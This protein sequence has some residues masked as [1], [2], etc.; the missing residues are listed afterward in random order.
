[1]SVETEVLGQLGLTEAEA[2][3]YLV[4]IELGSSQAVKIVTSTGMHR[5]TVY[6]AIERLIE[7]GLVSYVKH[8]NIR[9]YDAVNPERLKQ[10]ISEREERLQEV[11]PR[12][13]SIFNSPKEKKETVFF[14]GKEAVK[15]VFDD[16]ILE[17]KEILIMG[18]AANAQDI[19]K[20]YFSHFDNQR[21][22]RNIP[23]K[24]IFD[25]SARNLDYVKKIPLAQIKYLPREYSSPAATNI[26]GDKV[27]IILWTDSPIAILIKQ[28]EIADSY[29]NFFELMWDVAKK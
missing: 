15:A 16:Q 3:T 7:K 1:M 24:L 12:L 28:K 21:K 17:G 23:V 14:R 13:V 25:E 19:V 27:S 10:I 20:Y 18:A 22:K 2:K 4:L 26:Y 9:Y 11:M 29:R 6:D 8:N 5:R